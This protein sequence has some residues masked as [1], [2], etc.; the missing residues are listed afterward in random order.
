M[1]YLNFIVTAGCVE[2]AH[3]QQYSHLCIH[4]TD[5]PQE[6]D[7]ETEQ[8]VALVKKTKLQSDYEELFGP[9]YASTNAQSVNHTC[10]EEAPVHRLF[11]HKGNLVTSQSNSITVEE[12]HKQDI[13]GHV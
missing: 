4:S 1:S 3:I 6:D 12:K 13:G 2:R 7:S 10:S 11:S 9:L 5:N 8:P